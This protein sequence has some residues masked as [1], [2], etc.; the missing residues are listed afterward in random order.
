[1]RAVTSVIVEKCV[2]NFLYS[3]HGAPKRCGARG[4]LPL[5]LSVVNNALI[6][7]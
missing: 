6:M 7:H 1:M 4:N 3:T 5:V 2:S